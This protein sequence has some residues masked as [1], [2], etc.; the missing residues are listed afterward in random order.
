MKVITSLSTQVEL[1]VLTSMAMAHG[2][3]SA[4]LVQL[5]RTVSSIP[6]RRNRSWPGLVCFRTKTTVLLLVEVSG[7]VDASGVVVNVVLDVS[8]YM[9]VERLDEFKLT[10]A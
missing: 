8:C 3:V 10:L 1:W 4:S 5:G 6:P 9:K 2:D 7:V